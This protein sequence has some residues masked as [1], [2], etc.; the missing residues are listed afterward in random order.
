MQGRVTPRGTV[1]A[2]MFPIQPFH[3]AR[4]ANINYAIREMFSEYFKKFMSVD[5]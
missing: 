2:E 1:E 5:T 3:L 4:A